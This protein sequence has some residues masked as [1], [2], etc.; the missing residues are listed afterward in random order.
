L[1]SVF[2]SNSDSPV[3]EPQLG[4]SV[5][6]DRAAQLMSVS[7]RTVYN[8]IR[9]GRLQTIRT[10]CGSQRV[11]VESLQNLGLRPQPFSSSPAAVAFDGRPARN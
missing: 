10:R 5:S 8:R 6:I 2:T 11:L 1:P 9:D 4:R 7:R 3:N